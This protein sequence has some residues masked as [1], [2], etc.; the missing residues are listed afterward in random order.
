MTKEEN[1]HSVTEVLIKHKNMLELCGIPEAT[2]Y[3]WLHKIVSYTDSIVAN[4]W[5]FKNRNK[6]RPGIQIPMSGALDLA[7]VIYI[8]YDDVMKWRNLFTV[9]PNQ[10]FVLNMREAISDVREIWSTRPFRVRKR[11]NN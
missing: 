8:Q 1:I 4:N 11:G 3:R 5:M 9:A 6:L 7:R 2:W 10:E